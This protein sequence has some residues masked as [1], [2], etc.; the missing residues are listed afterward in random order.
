MKY[1]WKDAAQYAEIYKKNPTYGSSGVGKTA[2][3]IDIIKKYKIGSVMDFGCGIN[4]VL[5]KKIKSIEPNIELYGY[6]PAIPEESQTDLV[7]N[8]IDENLRVDLVI[9]TDCLEHIPKE[10]LQ[11]C[12]DI[13]N[14]LDPMVMF[15]SVCTRKAGQILGDGTNAHKTIQS[16]AWWETE[17]L[18]GFDRYHVNNIT[19]QKE[20]DTQHGYYIIVKK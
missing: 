2:N 5:L 4:A 12:W 11:Q 14:K 10:E 3:V 19:T 8:Y 1:K 17:F 18:R 13:F 7:K 15:H 16:H 6:D 20:I 9:S